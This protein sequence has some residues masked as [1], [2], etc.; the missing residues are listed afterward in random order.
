[1]GKIADQAVHQAI[2]IDG[3]ENFIF[4]FIEPCEKNDL[5]ER[6]KYWIDHFNSNE[7][8]YNKTKGGA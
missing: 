6:E 2:R 1:M 8:G 7:Y 5:N 4:E 3:I